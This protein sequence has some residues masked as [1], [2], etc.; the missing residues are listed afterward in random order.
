[1]CFLS[2][3]RLMKMIQY[4]GEDSHMK[5]ME[6]LLKILNEIPE[7]DQSGSGLSFCDQKHPNPKKAL[8]GVKK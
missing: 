6:C 1:M 2:A 7:G 3:R 8:A 4:V 5:Q